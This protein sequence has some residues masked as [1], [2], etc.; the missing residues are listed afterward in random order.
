MTFVSTIG[1]SQD[2]V[3]RLKNLQ[4]QLGTLQNQVATGKK[5]QLFKG[6]DTDV[7]VTKRARADFKKLETYLQNI[8]RADNRIQQMTN[9]LSAIQKQVNDVIDAVTNQT[10]KGEVELD[11]IRR[12]AENS[13]DMIIDVLNQKDGDAFIFTGSDTS[14]QPLIE[15]GSLDAYYGNLNAQW[16]SGLLPITPPNTTIDQEYISRYQNIPEVTLGLSGSLQ[17]AKQVFVRA[18]DTV[19]I[20]YTVLANDPAFKDIISAITALKNIADLDAA[21]GVDEAAQEDN[22]FSVFNS[23]AVTLT[24]AVDSL[25]NERFKLSTA[26]VQ[27]SRIKTDHTYE[28]NVLQNTIADVE[29]IDLNEVALKVT[30]LSTQLEASYQVTAL[31]SQLNLSNYL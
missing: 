23:I 30:A 26:Q 17:N 27:M 18:D 11:F 31:I 19:E 4:V 22:F 16:S 5:T 14:T 21:P 6:L 7:V 2:Q 1:Q 13:F 28:K 20:N 29:N 12:L 8:E 9:G 25:D 3:A 10:Q 15:T 24:K